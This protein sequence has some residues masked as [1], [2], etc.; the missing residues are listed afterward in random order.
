MFSP[1]LSITLDCTEC[2]QRKLML[3][4]ILS[5]GKYQ[6]TEEGR[7]GN[8]KTVYSGVCC[9]CETARNSQGHEVRCAIR[10]DAVMVVWERALAE[11]V[12]DDE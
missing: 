1:L 5:L 8:K 10:E 9:L 2:K 7:R 6:Q 11:G 12:E 3:V 4:S